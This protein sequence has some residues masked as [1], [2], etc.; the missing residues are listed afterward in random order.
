MCEERN[1][2]NIKTIQILA[3][4]NIE[5]MVGIVKMQPVWAINRKIKSEKKF[6]QN[7][8]SVEMEQNVEN[9]HAESKGVVWMKKI[10]IIIN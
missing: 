5:I 4:W 8:G 1:G 3:N 9:I 6:K 7:G 2:I 10:P